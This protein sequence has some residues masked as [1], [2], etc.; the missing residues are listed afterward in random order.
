MN[1][2]IIIEVFDFIGGFKDEITNQRQF[3]IKESQYELLIWGFYT[4]NPAPYHLGFELTE[5]GKKIFWGR[6]YIREI[7]LEVVNLRKF[8]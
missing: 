3:L 5:E 6:D 1:K 2:Y 7:N 4:N 8:L